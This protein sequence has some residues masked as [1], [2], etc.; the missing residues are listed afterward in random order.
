MVTLR[1]SISSL[2]RQMN[3]PATW[4]EVHLDQTE[5]EILVS[6]RGSR[7]EQ[8]AARNLGIDRDVL[9]RVGLAVEKAARRHRALETGVIEDAHRIRAALLAGDV[10]TLFDRL[11]EAASGPLLVRFMVGHRE[12]QAMTW[13]ALC[14]EG[15]ALGFWGVATNLLPVRGVISTDPWQP[16]EV[17]GAVKV[18]VIA[19]NGDAGVETLKQALAARTSTGEMEWLEPIVG[20]AARINSFPEQL[21]SRP[22]PHVIHFLGHGAIMNGVPSVRMADDD[23]EE[24]WLAAEL[25]ASHF[26]AGFSSTLRLVVLEVCEGAR[27]SEFGS[28]AE[29]LAKKGADAVVAF[30]WPVTADTARTC[31][32]EFY[33]VLAGSNEAGNVAIATNA[34]RRMILSAHE[35]SAEAL[36]PVL[37]LRGPNGQ[38]FDFNARKPTPALAPTHTRGPAQPI[39]I[40]PSLTRIIRAPF[41]LVLGD[42]W[43]DEREARLKFRSKLHNELRQAS[44]S[45]PEGLPMGTVAQWFALHRGP[46]K[47]GTEFQKSFQATMTP[48]AI[49]SAIARWLGPGVHTTLLR[50]SWLESSLAA[51]QPTRTIYVI[52]PDDDKALFMRR[53]AHADDWEDL[54]IL[55]KNLNINEDI[56]VLRPYRGYTLYNT[57]VRPLLTEDEYHLRL[58]ELWETKIMPA[59]LA[60]A[61]LRVLAYRPALIL[62]LSMLTAH[63]RMLLHNLF[64]DGIPRE[65]VA[66]IDPQD[67]ESALWRSGGGLPG[68]RRDI[69]I[70]ETAEQALS[71][72]LQSMPKEAAQ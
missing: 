60:N 35:N 25:L 67:Q 42:R 39:A 40:P 32:T 33:R 1:S 27:P 19:P 65:S 47:L 56:V 61:M 6:A 68:A 30:S 12:L 8:T 7:N 43:Q 62:G 66:V 11:R 50:N 37:Y 59:D 29:I 44:I 71:G 64:V 46:A 16:R 57:Y 53:Q 5:N 28:A 18:L 36:S 51:E 54:D 69:D 4:I 72:I 9:A 21:R 41:S 55:P 10:G 70:V 45:L 17:R 34:A 3:K 22:A 48:P 52:Q 31:S 24:K 38:I 20:E 49:V 63:H 13:E 2:D 14:I 26:A 15:E 23:G 58:R